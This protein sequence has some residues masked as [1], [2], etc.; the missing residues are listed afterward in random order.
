MS[1]ALETCAAIKKKYIYIYM[2]EANLLD[3]SNI[4][5]EPRAYRSFLCSIK[6]CRV[7]LPNSSR[8]FTRVLLL[9]TITRTVHNYE[10]NV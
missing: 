5:R 1:V 10:N 2:V 9:Y 3:S 7:H 8:L 4:V 6:W